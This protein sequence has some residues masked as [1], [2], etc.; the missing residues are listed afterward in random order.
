M[1][2]NCECGDFRVLAYGERWECETCGRRWNT[3]QIPAEEY[4]SFARAVRR[5]QIV[6]GAFIAVLLAIFVPLIVLVDPRI[7]FSGLILA[8][9]WS[10]FVRPRQRRKLL[11]RARGPRWELRQE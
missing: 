4:R 7:G 3:E 1:R 9:V 8:F 6:S 5:Y 11:E 2:V 10:T